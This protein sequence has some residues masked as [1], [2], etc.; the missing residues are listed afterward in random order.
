MLGGTRGFKPTPLLPAFSTIRKPL[1]LN[2]FTAEK[3][4]KSS[5]QAEVS[6]VPADETRIIIESEI[7]GAQAWADRHGSGFTWVPETLELRVVLTQLG[8]I[9]RFYL[10]GRFPG[11]RALAPEWTFSDENWGHAGRLCDAPNPAPTQF[12]SSIFIVYENHAL[13]IPKHAVICVPFN[14]L[15]YTDGSGPHADWGGP[16]Q[17]ME[18]SRQPP[19]PGASPL[20]VRAEMVGDMLQVICRDFVRST[21]RMGA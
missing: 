11:Y 16:A 12:G 7:R 8:G 5:I 15:A 3:S 13:S 4:W 6:T 10:R 21:G 14:R 17:W 2:T 9:D 18:V 19:A 1:K 20:P